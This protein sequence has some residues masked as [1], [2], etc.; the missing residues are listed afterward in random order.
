[1]IISERIWDKLTNVHIVDKLVWCEVK[2]RDSTKVNFCD[3]TYGLV[4]S[5]NVYDRRILVKI[6]Q[7]SRLLVR[8]KLHLLSRL[9]QVVTLLHQYFTEF[10]GVV[11]F[12]QESTVHTER[13]DVILV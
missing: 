13:I 7:R 6:G 1:M 8:T 12:F 2:H 3:L 4:V 11:V 9:L 10:Y 5:R